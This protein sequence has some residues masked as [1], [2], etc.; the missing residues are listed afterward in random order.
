MVTSMPHRMDSTASASHLTRL[1]SLQPRMARADLNK[2][3]NRPEDWRSRLGSAISQAIAAIGWSQKEAAAALDIDQGQFA[4]WIHGT[5]RPQF[6]RLFAVDVL[7][8]PL[9]IA[10]ARLSGECEITTQISIKRTA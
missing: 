2:V 5:E 4:K 1:E 8:G 3:E 6:D 7:R 10:L 9:V